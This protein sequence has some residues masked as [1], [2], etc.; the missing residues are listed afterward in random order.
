MYPMQVPSW[1]WAMYRQSWTA[2]PAG[3]PTR[4]CP[5]PT[6]RL[7]PTARTHEDQH[8]SPCSPS[9]HPPSA[10]SVISHL[11]CPSSLHSHP[12]LHH[13]DAGRKRDV[14]GKG[15]VG[16]KFCL[17]LVFH[18]LLKEKNSPSLHLPLFPHPLRLPPL[19]FLAVSPRASICH[20][21]IQDCLLHESKWGW[22]NHWGCGGWDEKK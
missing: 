16:T 19:L 15:G 1:A 8:S 3:R 7:P 22:G 4:T 14:G 6:R 20:C 10:T 17:P 13:S 5:M 9:P 21:Y 11:P 12:P 18:S 2:Y